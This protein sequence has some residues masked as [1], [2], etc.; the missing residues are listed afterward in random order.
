MTQ[1][2][3]EVTAIADLIVLT[4]LPPKLQINASGHVTSTGWTNAQLIPYVYIQAPPDGIYDFDF[5][6]EP[7]D[8]VAA[9]AISAI[10][11]SYLW[12]AFPEGLKGVR[13]HAST[14]SL[15]KLLGSIEEPTKKEPAK[16]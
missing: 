8:E 2:I 13:I 16:K 4:S 14:N 3:L 10:E 12:D 6:A 11:A 9:Q 7:P 15:E 1:K 5:V